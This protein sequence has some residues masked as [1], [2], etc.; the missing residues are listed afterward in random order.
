MVGADLANKPRRRA[1]RRSGPTSTCW[2]QTP[3]CPRPGG[4]TF[5]AR[6]ARPRA[7]REPARADAADARAAARR[8]SSAARATSSSSRRWPARSR[9]PGSSVYS[10]TKFGM[11]GFGYALGEEL[12]GTGVGVT[13]VFPGF[14]RDAGMFAESGTKLPR[15]V[16]TRTPERRRRGGRRG[17]REGPRRDRRGAVLAQLGRE[18]VR[19]LAARDVADHPA[20]RRRPR[21]RPARDGSAGQALEI[22]GCTAAKA[23]PGKLRAVTLDGWRANPRSARQPLG[24]VLRHER[25]GVLDSLEARVREGLGKRSGVLPAG[26]RPSR[27]PRRAGRAVELA[28]LAPR[29]RACSGRRCRSGPSRGRGARRRRF[30]PAAPTR[31]SPPGRCPALRAS[32]SR[33]GRA[34]SP[35]SASAGATTMRRAATVPGA[36]SHLNKV[37]G[38]LS[39]AS[40][41]VS[42]SRPIRSGCRVTTSW[43][44]APPVSLPTSV[45][46]LEVE[47]R[48]EVGD[49]L[50]AARAARGRRRRHRHARASRAAGRERCSGSPSRAPAR[51]CATGR[52]SRAAPWMNTIGSPEPRSR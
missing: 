49:Q 47:R 5:A 13:T 44:S 38:K 50:R 21:E 10:A 2:S 39:K 33:A 17:D 6:R 40:Q 24:L 34:A 46:S 26:R 41:G 14:I 35:C 30:A 32:R 28:Q 3:R 36:S 22:T 25:V 43:Q 51:P 12:R 48:E 18:D 8:C 4:S 29:P 27:A 45:T 11:R 7:R 42:T 23:A 16:G 15:G 1:P 9:A 20:A 37:G 19:R 52:R 31:P